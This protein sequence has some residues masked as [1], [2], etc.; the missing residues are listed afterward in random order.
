MNGCNGPTRRRV[1]QVGTAAFGLSLT[2]LLQAEARAAAPSPGSAGGAPRAKS[3]II[4]Y[5]SGGP[6]QLDMWDLKP[7]APEAIRGTFRPIR[8]SVPGIDICEHLPRM[9]GLAHHYTIVRSMTHDDDNHVTAG[10]YVLTGARHAV[11][12]AQRAGMDRN[13]R[14]HAGAIVARSLGSRQ[15]VP[16][17]CMIPEYVSPVGVPRPGQ[18]AGFFGPAYDPYLIDS[19]PNEPDYDPGPLSIS[20]SGRLQRTARLRSL[21]ET[22][23]RQAALSSDL[24]AVR[25]FQTF[26]EKALDLLTSPAAQQ[27]L[28]V[29]LEPD[30]VRDRYGRHHFGQSALVARRLIEAGSRLVQVNFMRHDFGKGGQGYDSHSALGYPPHLPWL[31]DE[32]LPP[33]DAAFASLVE[34]LHDRGLLDETIVVM[35]GEFGRTPK[36]NADAGRDHWARCYSLVV[37]GGGFTA[38]QVYGASDATASTVTADPVTP[39][40]LLCTVYQLLGIDHRGEVVDLENRP[41]P[42]IEGEPVRGLIA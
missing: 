30:S 40:G 12:L 19:D 23:E 8:T 29:T 33:T 7:E 28:D 18:H 37:A 16:P 21:L 10:Y 41:M 22:A 24:P 1:L 9:A 36:F 11:S 27:A 17:F 26:R 14:P 5:L 32:L 42:M 20:P 38:G 13:D 35:M 39:E 4:L 6:S 2:R 3:V 15:N 34:D 25:D 31:V